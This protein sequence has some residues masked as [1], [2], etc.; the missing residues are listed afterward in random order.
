MSTSY[1][2][3]LFRVIYRRNCLD[4]GSAEQATRYATG[5]YIFVK[6][7]KETMVTGTCVHQDVT[8]ILNSNMYKFFSQDD[9]NKK[10]GIQ[11]IQYGN[12]YDA[13]KKIRLKENK[14]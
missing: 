12:A 2:I 1:T 4:S 13:A 10:A 14:F 6:V 3:C 5:C 7:I 9:T 8:F 11:L